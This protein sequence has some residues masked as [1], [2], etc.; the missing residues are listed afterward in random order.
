VVVDSFQFLGG[1]G[2][3]GQ[4]GARSGSAPQRAAYPAPA[5]GGYAPPAAA[6]DPPAGGMEEMPPLEESPS[7]DEIPF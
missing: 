3:P 4:G 6:Y 5:A 1:P 7:G 2:G